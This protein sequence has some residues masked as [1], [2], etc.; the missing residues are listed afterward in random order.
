M[1]RKVVKSRYRWP[2]LLISLLG[3]IELYK[4]DQD[5]QFA[6]ETTFKPHIIPFWFPFN[7]DNHYILAMAYQIW[8]IYQTLAINGAVQALINSVMVFLRANLKILQYQIRNFDRFEDYSG[9]G[10]YVANHA[11]KNLR[12]AVARHQLLIQ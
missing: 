10:T 11:E 2:I 9:N 6:N 8:H 4:W 1:V 5:M 7:K 12:R 3:F